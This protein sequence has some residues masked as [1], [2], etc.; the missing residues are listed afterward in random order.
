MPFQ[1]DLKQPAD[2]TREVNSAITHVT[3]ATVKRT[4]GHHSSA[5]HKLAQVEIATRFT[6]KAARAVLYLHVTGKATKWTEYLG[7][8]GHASIK[9]RI[10]RDHAAFHSIASLF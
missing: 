10:A 4:S 3:I 1:L 2:K 6:E 5:V 8:G 9:I 7:L